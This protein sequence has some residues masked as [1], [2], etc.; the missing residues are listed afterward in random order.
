[1]STITQS[2]VHRI[3]RWTDAKFNKKPSSQAQHST[4]TQ[5]VPGDSHGS[6]QVSTKCDIS[7]L[8]NDYERK[9]RYTYYEKEEMQ[10][11]H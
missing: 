8:T 10:F 1:M 7:N 6:S 9:T 5:N 11:M 3:G 4:P 2:A